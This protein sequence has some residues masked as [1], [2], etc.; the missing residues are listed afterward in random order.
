[1][2]DGLPM[3]RRLIAIAAISFGNFLVVVDGNIATVALPSIA[4]QLGAD[5]S[6]TVLIVTIY[7]LTLVMALLPFSSLGDRIGLQRMYQYG[8]ILFTISALLIFFAKSLPFLLVLR[9]A[10]ALGA[11]MALSVSAALLRS[12]YPAAQLGRGL[13]LNTV[14]V[15]SAGALAPIM[16]GFIIANAPWPWV[17]AAAVPFGLLSLAFG[18]ALPRFP[19][20]NQPYDFQSALMSAATFGLIIGGLESGVH[21]DSPVV[22]G[23]IMVAGIL[24]AILFVRRELLSERPVMP[25]DLLKKPVIA[26]SAIGGMA[27]FIAS[28]TLM[29]SLPF[30]LE[31]EFGFSP[32]VVGT[33]ISPWGLTMLVVAPLAGQLSDRYPAGLLGGIGMALAIAGL[34]SLAFL[35]AHPDRIDIVWRMVLTGAGFGTFASPNVRQILGSAPRERTAAAGGLVSTARLTGQTIG[36]TVAAALLAA[37]IGSGPTPALV[38]AGLATFALLCSI[39]RLNPAIRQPDSREVRQAEAGLSDMD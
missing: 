29:L 27:A 37:G 18:R 1:M 15:A 7:Q 24:T 32:G 14:I 20:R 26:L 2:T 23:A 31:N 12:I 36:A 11:G 38:A 28:M 21:G 34:L 17:F 30:R 6:A 19:K 8:Q 3:P 16:G 9:A 22:S 39:A 10:Q 35:P 5:S 4:K 13:G 25:V 33:I